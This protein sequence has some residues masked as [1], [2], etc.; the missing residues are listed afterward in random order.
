[1]DQDS[2]AELAQSVF[3]QDPLKL[4]LS[5]EDDLKQLLLVGLQVREQTE[6]FQEVKGEVL[7]LVN[8]QEDVFPPLDSVQE[9]VINLLYE[10]A[11]ASAR[12]FLSEFRENRFQKLGL[13]D[14]RIEDQGALV[15]LVVNLVNEMTTKRGLS[16][17]YFSGQHYE[18]LFLCY[19]VLQVLEGLLVSRAQ[20]EKVG[21]GSNVERHLFEAV[22]T[23]IHLSKFLLKLREGCNYIFAKEKGLFVF[24]VCPA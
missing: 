24:S 3:T 11:T 15:L 14:T 21:I 19:A 1:M 8:D 7:G 5:H 16:A 9:D 4:G 18:S 20:V 13:G 17:S 10:A 23:L 6:L 22:E 12:A 2:L